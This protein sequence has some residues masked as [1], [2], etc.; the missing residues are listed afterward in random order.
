MKDLT[1]MTETISQP[2]VKPKRKKHYVNNADLLVE[3]AE[4]NRIDQMT[5]KLID[6][7]TLMAKGLASKGRFINYTYKD[8]MQAF[9][10]LTIVMRW[11]KFN[12]ERGNNPFAYFTQVIK[13]AFFQFDNDER[14]ERDVKDEIKI[15]LGS[16]PTYSYIDRYNGTTKSDYMS[17]W[18]SDN[19][20]PYDNDWVDSPF[21]QPSEEISEQDN[22]ESIPE[23][24]NSDEENGENGEIIVRKTTYNDH[25]KDYT[26]NSPIKTYT[27]E[28]YAELLK[29]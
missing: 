23:T 14:A 10:M 26:L 29:Q 2:V 4:S 7:L 15:S 20:E 13:N 1:K 25:K 28:E 6:M 12:I 16:N 17:N 19:P 11:K 3:L 8:E 22:A 18:D 9:A 27:P 24:N 21:D 5:P